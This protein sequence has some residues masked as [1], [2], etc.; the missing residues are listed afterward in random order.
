M[1][2]PVSPGLPVSAHSV[3]DT[4]PQLPGQSA[5]AALRE[6]AEVAQAADDLGFRRF[7]LGEQHGVRGV[8]SAAPAV[9]AA[10]LAARTDRIRLGAG[11]VLLTN[12]Q[13]LVIAEQFAALAAAYPSRI[14]L[15][16]GQQFNHAPS[17]AAALGGSARDTFPQRLD[18]LCGFLRDGMPGR[19]PV[20]EVR[21]SLAGLPPPVL[22]VADHPGAASIAAMRGLPVVVQHHTATAMTSAAVAAYRDQFEASGP[23]VKPYL[24]VTVG[25]VA[26]D[27]EAEAIVRFAEY[28]RV[29]SRLRVAPPR[30]TTAELMAL[31]DPPLTGR[32]R[33]RAERLLDDP[34]H[35]VGSRTSVV[36]ALGELVAETTADEV[37]LVPLAFDGLVRSSILRTIAAGLTRTIR[38]VPRHAPPLIATA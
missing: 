22:V 35:I 23:T 21:L 7:W 36:S 24:A 8:G 1:L 26:A 15:G 25:V 18:E 30:A 12:H 20:G 19:A 31:L 3:L 32:E 9:L 28:V 27:T 4:V 6:T 13:P 33:G 34:G 10:V 37:M 38:T 5:A 29:K 11:G 17:T 16:V 14:D 2:S